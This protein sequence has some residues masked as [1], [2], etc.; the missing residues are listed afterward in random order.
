[1]KVLHLFTVAVFLFCNVACSDV[2]AD[3]TQ[4]IIKNSEEAIKVMEQNKHEEHESREVVSGGGEEVAE[5]IPKTEAELK[6]EEKRAAK[7]AKAREKKF[8]HRLEIH[9]QSEVHRILI[10]RT[11]V[12]QPD[13]AGVANNVINGAMSKFNNLHAFTFSEP[14]SFNPPLYVPVE[15]NDYGDFK[16][17]TDFILSSSII[18]DETSQK[19]V[20]EIKLYDVFFQSEILKKVYSFDVKDAVVLHTYIAN[21]IYEAVTGD[22]GLIG[23]KIMYVSEGIV[24]TKTPNKKI[25][26]MNLDSL[27]SKVIVANGEI[28]LNPIIF[29]NNIIYAAFKT[30]KSVAYPNLYFTNMSSKKTQKIKIKNLSL[31]D[32][33]VFSPSITKDGTYLAFSV[34][35]NGATQIYMLDLKTGVAKQFTTSG[36]INTSPTFSPDARYIAYTSNQIGVSQIYIGETTHNN[37]HKV[38]ASRG[39]Y[40]SPTFSPDGKKLSFVKILNGVFNVGAIDLETEEETIAYSGYFAENPS[41]INSETLIFSCKKKNVDKY[42]VPCII[43]LKTRNLRQVDILNNV[44]QASWAGWDLGK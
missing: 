20:L 17:R 39:M 15:I 44:S 7:E 27:S 28:V 21:A 11:F 30:V 1:M 41:W 32:K 16:D 31:D 34:A 33:V 14:E 18:K 19:Y 42:T 23:G 13:Y 36:T 22:V 3:T 25:E 24:Q 38:S 29:N 5:E 4:D 35:Y 40:L 6:Q 12:Q 10:G 37:L 2:F 43:S 26:I 8:L 9:R